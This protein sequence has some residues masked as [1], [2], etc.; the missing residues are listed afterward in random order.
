MQSGFAARDVKPL[1]SVKKHRRVSEVIGLVVLC[2]AHSH[3]DAATA[4]PTAF[5][6]ERRYIER[7]AGDFSHGIII[8]RQ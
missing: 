4:V 3:V 7:H 5:I 2:L 6:A 1:D 8:D